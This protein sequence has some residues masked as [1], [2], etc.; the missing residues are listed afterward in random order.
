[1][2][3]VVSMGHLDYAASTYLSPAAHT[4]METPSSVAGQKILSV[5][6]RAV[7]RHHEATLYL[8][9]RQVLCGFEYRF[10]HSSYFSGFVE[11]HWSSLCGPTSLCDLGTFQN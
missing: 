5:D 1:M 4:M 3:T 11:R 10:N 9:E 7:R 6:C 8:S 2:I